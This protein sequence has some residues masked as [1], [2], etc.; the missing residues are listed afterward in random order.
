MKIIQPA[1]NKNEKEIWNLVNKTCQVESMKRQVI[2]ASDNSSIW[3]SINTTPTTFILIYA[4]RLINI[5][6][7]MNCYTYELLYIWVVV[8]WI[9][10]HMNFIHMNCYTYELLYAWIVI[11]MNIYIYELLYA[12]IIIHM[13]CYTYELLHIWILY[14][15]IV[16]HMNCYTYQLLHIW[17][18]IL[19]YPDYLNMY[20]N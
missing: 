13:N 18:V 17:I 12:W 10:I 7:H 15:W 2:I 6:I 3:K 11:R 20:S 16:I 1:N 19:M 4:N 5:V 8:Q 9:V 14:I